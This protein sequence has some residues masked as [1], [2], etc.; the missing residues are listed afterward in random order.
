M[1][2]SIAMRLKQVED[3]WQ[4]EMRVS[5][6]AAERGIIHDRT[7]PFASEDEGRAGLERALLVAQDLRRDGVVTSISVTGDVESIDA[8]EE[9]IS[10]RDRT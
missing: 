4:V 1:T 6:E 5:G 2:G 3:V 9:V 7:Y 10:P 8:V